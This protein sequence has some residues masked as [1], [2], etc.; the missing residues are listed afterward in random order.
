[1]K[2]IVLREL[3]EQ[4][5]WKIRPKELLMS[6]I[7]DSD[8]DIVGFYCLH[9]AGRGR[10]RV[11][12]IYIHPDYRGMGYALQAYKERLPYVAFTHNNNSASYK[13]HQKA[14]F[15][16]WYKTKSGWYWKRD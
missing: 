1:M 9:P 5:G 8:G 14:G 4:E 3:A 6:P 10:Y 12:P 13:L 15:K 11:G 2:L 16:R 7:Y